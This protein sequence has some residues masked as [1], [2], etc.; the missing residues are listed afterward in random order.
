M[1]RKLVLPAL[2]VASALLIAAACSGDDDSDDAG[3]A[4]APTT[5]ASEGTSPPAPAATEEA[6]ST[7]SPAASPDAASTPSPDPAS[8]AAPTATAASSDPNAEALAA[9]DGLVCGGG[10]ENLTFGSTGSVELTFDIAA[11][12]SGG[13]LTMDIGGN[14][15]GAS[16]GTVSVPFTRSGAVIT[17]EAD[18][19]FLGSLTAVFEDGVLQE[20]TFDAPPALGAEASVAVSNFVFDGQQLAADI[21]IDFGGGGGSA[22]SRIEATCSG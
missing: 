15:F 4:A 22:Q 20:A 9:L 8:T 12:A 6:T 18:L 10:W 5:A 17:A 14:V 13:T 1:I 2:L 11:D 3:G 21:E 19:G 16:G 7:P